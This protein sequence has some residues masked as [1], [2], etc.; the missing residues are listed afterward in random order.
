MIQLD[1]VGGQIGQLVVRKF[2]FS[3]VNI[4]RPSLNVGK[5]P[6]GGERALFVRAAQFRAI[7]S[8]RSV[9]EIVQN[10]GVAELA[11]I[12]QVFGQLAERVPGD[13]PGRGDLA[14]KA[15]VK[16]IITFDFLRIVPFIERGVGGVLEC[17]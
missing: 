9:I 13:L 17:S 1:G 15:G 5:I 12:E 6:I 3:R 2:V 8:A 11:V 16:I 14:G 10:D 4:A 7:N